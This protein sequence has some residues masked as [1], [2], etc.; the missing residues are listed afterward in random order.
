MKREKIMSD[1]IS[2]FMTCAGMGHSMV[3]KKTRARRPPLAQLAFFYAMWLENGPSG[4][5]PIKLLRALF[6]RLQNNVLDGRLRATCAENSQG[7]FV[8]RVG[9]GLALRRLDIFQIVLNSPIERDSLSCL[10]V[11]IAGL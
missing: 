3:A 11:V 2:V 10:F 5:R 8:G 4:A 9:L 7:I 1:R 6:K